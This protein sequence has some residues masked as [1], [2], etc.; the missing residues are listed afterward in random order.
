MR[1]PEPKALMVDP[2]QCEV[3]NS[4]LQD[5]EFSEYINLYKEFIGLT[6]GTIIDLGSGSCKFIVALSLEFPNLKFVCYE[7]SD[8][9]I[10]IAK[11]IIEDN[12]L[13]DRITIVKNNLMNATG[14]YDAVL[15]NRVLHH[16][17]DTTSLWKLINRLSNKVLAVDLLR[18]NDTNTLDRFI[19]KLGLFFNKIY[20]IDTE[21]SFKAAYSQD[22][23]LEQVNPYGYN[24]KFVTNTFDDVFYSKVI[25]YHSK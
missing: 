25:I 4:S 9:M 14:T 15:L 22:E 7:D 11:K 5:Q 8:A 23:I 21:N 12:N 2:V 19:Q 24:V 3:Y 10:S 16:I 18:F 13:S 1:I 20:V 17:D 6:S